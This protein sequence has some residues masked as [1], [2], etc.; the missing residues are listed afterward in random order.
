MWWDRSSTTWRRLLGVPRSSTRWSCWSFGGRR[1]RLEVRSTRFGPDAEAAL[2][3]LFDEARE[4]KL[5]QTREIAPRDL[6]TGERSRAFDQVAQL[7][8]CR[9]MHAKAIGREWF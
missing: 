2:L 5:H 1:L 3:G 9:E 8:V 4:H 7:G 6:V